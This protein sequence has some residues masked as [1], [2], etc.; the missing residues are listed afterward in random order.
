MARLA[1]PKDVPQIVALFLQAK[2]GSDREAAEKAIVLICQ[3]AP[4]A[5]ERAEPCLVV[6][7]AAAPGTRIDLLP[8]LGRL[9]GAESKR[10][11]V[12]A[13]QSEDPG[14]Y[15]AAVRALSN[16]P[17]ASIAEDL[18]K[19]AQSDSQEP[20]RLLAFRAFIRVVS[21]PGTP[22]AQ[23]LAQLRR[24]M[25][26]ASRDEERNLILSRAAAVRTIDTLRFLVPYLDDPALAGQ[27]CRS[28]AELGRHKELR[29]PNRGEFMPA[30]K[31]V[32]A[33][34]HDAATLE[35]VRRNLAQ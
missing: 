7:R 28:V 29:E 30:L 32:L 11:I 23:R 12:A 34:S 31:K 18:L 26:L 35:L 16:W 24:A 21:T 17:D 1:E 13:L 4:N 27:A 9:G 3:Q 14:L 2:A 15:D 10:A 5:Q 22:D 20:H 6:F 19:I 33:T 25:R 8:L